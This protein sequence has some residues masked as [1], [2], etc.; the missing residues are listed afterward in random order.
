MQIMFVLCFIFTVSLCYKNDH[1]AKGGICEIGAA[2]T[3]T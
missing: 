2:K 3:G 1:V